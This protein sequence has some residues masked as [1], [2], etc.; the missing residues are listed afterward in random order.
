MNYIQLFDHPQLVTESIS[1]NFQSKIL[2]EIITEFPLKL[3]FLFLL[4]N[5]F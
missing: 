1:S 2:H 3:Y 5:V 4:K